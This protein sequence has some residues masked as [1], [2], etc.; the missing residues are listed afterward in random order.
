M[1]LAAAPASRTTTTVDRPRDLQLRVFVTMI[2]NV[3]ETMTVL[4]NIAAIVTEVDIPT[5]A[6]ETA[7]GR[8]IDRL[9]VTEI[10]RDDRWTEIKAEVTSTV[11][12]TVRSIPRSIQCPSG[13]LQ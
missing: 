7:L 6:Q 4:E 13:L 12:K 11:I 1:S 2:D 10:D 5:S 9:M 8:R 3:L